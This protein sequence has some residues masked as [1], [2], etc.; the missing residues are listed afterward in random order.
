LNSLIAIS[1]LTIA[2][3]TAISTGTKMSFVDTLQV[4]AEPRRRAII[5]LIWDDEMSAGEIASQFDVTF[6]ATSQHLTVL[7]E[8]K[9]VSVRKDGNKRFYRANQD[10]LGPYVGILEDMWA[11]T[12]SLLATSVEIDGTDQ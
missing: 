12:L 9:L 10:V 2:I 3:A 11:S 1:V 4:I 5:R 7:R 6:G 8:A